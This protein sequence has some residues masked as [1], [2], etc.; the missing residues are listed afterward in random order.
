MVLGGLLLPLLAHMLNSLSTRLIADDYCFTSDALA[1]G[2]VD[3]ITYRYWAWT[4]RYTEIAVKSLLAPLHTLPSMLL[5]SI[6]IV[7]WLIVAT[8][9]CYQITRALNLRQ[10]LVAALLAAGLILATLD[11]APLVMQSLYWTGGVIP[12]TLPL[13]M[14]AGFV[15]FTL[16]AI[17]EQRADRPITLLISLLLAFTAGGLSEVFTVLEVAAL[18]LAIPL[19][20]RGLPVASRRPATLILSVALVGAVIALLVVM[21]APGNTVRQ[22]NFERPDSV[23]DAVWQTGILAL[24]FIASTLVSFAPLQTLMLGITAFWIGFAFRQ[25]IP[26]VIQHSRSRWLL[27]AG[28]V[29]AALL[30]IMACIFP[31]VYATS[32]MP[33]ARAYI[34]PMFVVFCMIA[35]WG[36]VLGFGLR[37]RPNTQS[38]TRFAIILALFIAAAGIFLST[39]NLAVTPQLQTFAAEW[40]MRDQ[41]I[42]EQVAQGETNLVIQPLSVEMGA[43]MGLEDLE[44][45]SSEGFNDCAADYYGAETLTVAAT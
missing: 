10:P 2:L 41:F 1:L 38:T 16:V 29:F 20:W 11:S 4:G 40:D 8:W 13:I 24:A 5:P 32:N 12:Y 17:R 39:R 31:G 42:R 9:T 44:Q 22:S 19:A 45:G 36:L 25:S 33:P 14:A 43:L 23:L 34:L 30:L 6:L 27:L 37:W 3:A 28:S 15:G 18:A 35:T 21:A 26:P 7:F